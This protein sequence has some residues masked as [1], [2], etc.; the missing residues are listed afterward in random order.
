MSHR[1]GIGTAPHAGVGH[2]PSPLIGAA[3]QLVPREK[4]LR[5][6]ECHRDQ[7]NAIW[8]GAG[9]VVQLNTE[10]NAVGLR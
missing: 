9:P 2:R 6:V 1:I 5:P 3:V 4:G 7:P 10:W 8:V